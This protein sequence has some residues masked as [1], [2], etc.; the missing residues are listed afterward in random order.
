MNTYI[1]LIVMENKTIFIN[2]NIYKIY[3]VR[4]H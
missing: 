4:I 2:G 3:E 1:M